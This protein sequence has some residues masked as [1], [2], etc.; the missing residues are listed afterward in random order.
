VIFLCFHDWANLREFRLGLRELH[1]LLALPHFRNFSARSHSKRQLRRIR[2]GNRLHSW[3]GIL[4]G[5]IVGWK[6]RLRGEMGR[7]RSELG[8]VRDK[9]FR[10]IILSLLRVR[11]LRLHRSDT[12]SLPLS[13]SHT[14]TH[15]HTHT[16]ALSLSL[17]NSADLLSW[18]LSR[19]LEVKCSKST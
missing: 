8:M 18:S 10:R 16:L 9:K 17:S 3:R 12:F 1:T 4:R 14:H 5:R 7:E 11:L 15:S 13:L 2:R 6:L 19:P